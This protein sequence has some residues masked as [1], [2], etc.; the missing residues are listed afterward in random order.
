MFSSPEFWPTALDGRF[1][2]PQSPGR[3]GGETW[4]ESTS[5]ISPSLSAPTSAMDIHKQTNRKAIIVCMLI[6]TKANTY[7]IRKVLESGA[8]PEGELGG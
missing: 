8:D 6:L 3:S 5:P 7:Y 1:A 4:A 2:S